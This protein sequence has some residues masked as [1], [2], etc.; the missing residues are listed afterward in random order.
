M[1]I[2]HNFQKVKAAQF[3]TVDQKKCGINSEISFIFKKVGNSDTC[4][5]IDE[6]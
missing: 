1:F 5:N 3:L 2:I 6:S 4:Y